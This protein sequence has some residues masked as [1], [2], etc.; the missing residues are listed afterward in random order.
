MIGSKSCAIDD[1]AAPTWGLAVAVPQRRD[2]AIAQ[3]G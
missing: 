2:S 3:V 1:G